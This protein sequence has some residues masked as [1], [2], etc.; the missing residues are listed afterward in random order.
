MSPSLPDS[1]LA[2]I[3]EYVDALASHVGV[4][5]SSGRRLVAEA[6]DHLVEATLARVARGEAPDV[7]A[8][9]SVFAF[10]LPEVI[11]QAHGGGL[12]RSPSVVC[13]Q[14]VD[15]ACRIGIVAGLAIGASGTLAW[16]VGSVLGT[17]YVSGDALG[18]TY[19]PA[20]C[21]QYL[22]AYPGAGSCEN[23]AVMDHFDEVVWGRLLIGVLSLVFLGGWLLWRRRP[24]Y[25]RVP[26]LLVGV[27]GLSLALLAAAGLVLASTTGLL[28]A[29][30]VGTGAPLSAAVCAL[31][32]ALI[33]AIPVLRMIREGRLTLADDA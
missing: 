4:H 9:E 6:N 20:R 11:A 3:D 24:S 26:R 17:S 29:S 23:A 1:A 18:V 27:V 30:G 19:T 22:A 8:T 10:G 2:I 33:F 15:L 31:A 14:L 5:D 28:D 12:S 13:R 16:L 25:C 32:A 7:A 21:V